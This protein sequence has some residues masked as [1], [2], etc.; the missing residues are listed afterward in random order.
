MKEPDFL[1]DAAK[2]RR[3][4]DPIPGTE[5]QRVVEELIQS[6]KEIVDR[7]IAIAGLPP[8]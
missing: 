7:L 1:A 2:A 8:R 5:L 4:I 6:P 3:D